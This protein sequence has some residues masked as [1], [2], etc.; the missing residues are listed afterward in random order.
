VTDAG[1]GNTSLSIGP[2][3]TSGNIVI[4]AALGT[5]DVSIAAAQSAGGTVTIGSSSTA[6]SIGG[7]L[8]CTGVGFLGGGISYIAN[9]AASLSLTG[10]YN[11]MLFI[12]CGV[13]ATQ[14][15]T[16]PAAPPT[17]QYISFRVIKGAGGTVVIQGNGKQIYPN[18]SITN[19]ASVTLNNS[20]AFNI[21]YDSVEWVEY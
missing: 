2:S 1:A 10:T 5:G 8:S 19:V 20:Q 13:T 17:N 16:L 6:T 21:F 14:T 9:D 12:K 18:N 7:T 15:I 4:G 11:Y 3:A